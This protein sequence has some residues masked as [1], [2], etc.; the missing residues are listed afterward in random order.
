MF[1]L[2]LMVCLAADSS[3]CAERILPA[4]APLTKAE[5]EAGATARTA[6]WITNHPMLVPGNWQCLPTESLPALAFSEIAPGVY[7][8]QARAEPI[9]PENRGD[10]ANLSFIVGDTVAVIDVGGS[11][12]LGEELFAAIRQVTDRP[13]AYVIITHMHPDHSFGTDVFAEAGATVIGHE[14]L[15][16]GLQR[17]AETWAESIP[18]QIGV[19]ALLGTQVHLPDRVVTN[20][21]EIELG[22][23]TLRLVPVATAHTDNDLTVYHLQSG[24]LFSGDLIFADLLPSLDGSI[25]GWLAWLDAP[26]DPLPRQIVAGHG[27]VPMDWDRATGPIRGYLSALADETR[28]AIAAGEAMSVA[29]GHIGTKL[30]GTWRGFDDF[31]ARNAIAAYKE[32]EWE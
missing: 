24:I 28:T 22:G 27:P 3:V 10:I 30:R 6:I 29:S 32:L 5:C 25:I 15:T 11:R 16:S 7:V 19:R 13:I 23:A 31:N 26:P 9:S 21:E 12:A 2:A 14:N 18:R 20:P 17:R 1:H 8:H 4:P